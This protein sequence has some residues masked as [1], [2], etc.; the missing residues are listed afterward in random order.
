[1]KKYFLIILFFCVF[2]AAK[3][4]IIISDIYAKATPPNV[5]NTAIFMTIINNSSNDISLIKIS[6]SRSD[7]AEI[8]TNIQENG[9]MKMIRI[10]QLKIK[11]KD[12]HILEPKKD[13]IML[14]NIANPLIEGE[15]IDLT[16]N[17]DN[18]EKIKVENIPVVK[19]IPK[20]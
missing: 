6:S 20:N 8:H 7:I 1:M 5:V 15:K 17:F 12:S 13:H 19:K 9:M 4:N 16:L 3:E 11:A 14:I 18:G 10:P 2:L